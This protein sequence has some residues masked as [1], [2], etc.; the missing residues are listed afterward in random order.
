[1]F[2]GIDN[3]SRILTVDPIKFEVVQ[4]S[5]LSVVE[6]M[7]SALR[8]SAYSTNIKTRSDLSCALFDRSMRVIVQAFDQPAHLG[9]LRLC[10]PHVLKEHGVENLF[11]GD[12]II[13]NDPYRGG[14]HLNDIFLI[15]PIF[16]NNEIFGYVA[17][18]AHHVDVGGRAPSSIAICTEIY[19]EGLILPAVR[20]LQ[21]GEIDG[22][23]FKIFSANVRGKEAPGDFRAQVAAN[24]LGVRRTI[25]LIER[26]GSDTVNAVSREL[27]EYTQRRVKDSFREFPDGVYHAESMMD[28]DGITDEPVKVQVKLKISNGNVTIDLTGSDKQRR[29]PTNSNYSMTFAACA[30]VLK[31]LLPKDIQINDGF[32][33]SFEVTAPKGTVVNVEHPGPVVGGWELAMKTTEALIRALSKVFPLRVP[34]ESK[35]SIFHV[36]FGGLDPRTNE[37]YAFLET[38]GGGYGARPNMDGVDA[39][40]PHIQ[41]TENSPIEELEIGYPVYIIRYEIIPDTGGAGKYRGGCG[42][43]RDYLFRADATVTLLADTAKYPPRGLD[44]GLEGGVSRFILNPDDAEPRLLNSKQILEVKKGDVLRVETPGGGGY[45][46]PHQRNPL[47]ILDDVKNGKVSAREAREAYGISIDTNSWTYQNIRKSRKAP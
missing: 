4:N 28:D 12:G 38:I 10:V 31:C 44:G 37:H 42:V 29:G 13:V 41:N 5:I 19:Q 20:V 25:E 22:D 15:S 33:R 39:C 27:L 40:Q 23:I 8:R 7:T 14:G 35:K 32:Y 36:G 26:F 6:E 3:M 17:N 2:M 11:P 46:D 21:G 34:A 18:V 43:S 47:L 1:M 45:G 30:Y 9:A 24:K 16:N